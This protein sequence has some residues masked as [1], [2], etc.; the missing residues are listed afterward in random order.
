MGKAFSACFIFVVSGVAC[1]AQSDFGASFQVLGDLPGGTVLSIPRAISADGGVVVGESSSASSFGSCPQCRE[2]FQWTLGRGMI[3]LGDASGGVFWSSAAAVSSDGLV[4][5]IEGNI[6]GITGKSRALLWTSTNGLQD[7]LLSN[8]SGDYS[9]LFGFDDSNDLIANHLD[10]AGSNP[11]R[12]NVFSGGTRT[13]LP[14]LDSHTILTQHYSN[15]APHCVDAIV[16]GVSPNGRFVFGSD[17][18]LSTYTGYCLQESLGNPS[19]VRGFKIDR[20]QNTIES[21]TFGVDVGTFFAVSTLGSSDNGTTV[22]HAHQLCRLG[23]NSERC[24]SYIEG[25]GPVY[26]YADLSGDGMIA[27]AVAYGDGYFGASVWTPQFERADLVELLESAGATVTLSDLRVT[28]ISQ[29]GRVVAGYGSDG[30]D[31]I[32]WRAVLPF[33]YPCDSIDFNNDTSYFDPQDIDAFLSVYTEGPCIPSSATCNDL[34]FNNDGSV[35]D[36]IDIDA[37]LS[38]FSNGPCLLPS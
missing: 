8:S 1:Y 20:D 6:T 18:D 30:K 36:P 15:H 13:P 32:A 19:T 17:Y 26:D 24:F 38:V 4:V 25:D 21:Y 12:G 31:T 34:D 2:A 28:T 22:F 7:A 23:Q 5:G 33:G 37:F 16:T 3:G 29:D 27:V 11:V 9:W 14:S 35:F 10:D